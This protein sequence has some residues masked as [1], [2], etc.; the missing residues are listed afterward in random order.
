MTVRHPIRAKF[1]TGLTRLAFSI[2]PR[3]P[4]PVVVRL[5]RFFGAA[6]YRFSR[7]LR[8]IG[9][10]NLD[11]AFGDGKTATEKNRILRHSFQSFA[12]V[13]L[14]TFWF[15]RDSAA[16]I[17]RHVHFSPNFDVLFQHKPH[18]CVTAHY[19]NWEVLGMAV[20]ARGFPLHSVAKPL[21][22]PEVDRLFI[23]AR[24]RTGQQII[25]REGAVRSMFRILQGGG[26]IALVLDQN[27]RLSEGGRFFPFF[28][29][30]AL[31]AVAPAALAIKTR[32]DLFIGMLAPDRSGDYHDHHGQE[33]AIAPYLEGDPDTAAEALTSRITNQLEV[34]LRENPDHWLWTYKRWKYRP[35]GEPADR[36]PFYARAAR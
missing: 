13:L 34:F 23:D 16:R 10:A 11:L 19:G 9:Q 1:E 18:L 17:A 12:L 5:S 2:L 35:E 27:T 15:S 4:R 28:G 6:A 14:D 21:K 3:L 26:K 29:V 32:T 20:T 30:P 36:Y 7:K 31:V 22:N 24:R 33:I 25:R 8:R